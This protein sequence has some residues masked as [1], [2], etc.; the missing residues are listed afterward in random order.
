MLKEIYKKNILEQS[1]NLNNRIMSFTIK[2]P[3]L[4]KNIW[5][6]LSTQRLIMMPLIIFILLILLTLS[7][8]NC[9]FEYLANASYIGLILVLYLWGSKVAY[10][11]IISEYNERTW[12]WQRMSILTP[13]Q[14]V[15]G[16]L[17]GAP[18]Y[19][20]YGGI[21]CFI[22]WFFFSVGSEKVN[23][24]DLIINGLSFFMLII[25]LMSASIMFALLRIRKGSARNKLKSGQI[26]FA[27]IVFG[28]YF[29]G[30]SINESFFVTS[31][32]YTS[33]Q[34][35]TSRLTWSLIE[36]TFYAIWAVIGLHQ[37]FRH[38]L[39]YKNSAKLWYLFIFTSSI[40]KGVIWSNNFNSFDYLLNFILLSFLVHTI[41]I[42]Y[43]LIIFEVKDL[44][45]FRLLFQKIKIKDF[46][47]LSFNAP[48]WFLTFPL[49]FIGL[50]VNW[51]FF[52]SSVL[53]SNDNMLDDIFRLILGENRQIS[54]SY[55]DTFSLM[56]GIFFFIIRDFSL[57]LFLNFNSKDKRA[58]TAF[59]LYLFLLYFVFPIISSNN[60]FLKPFFYPSLENGTLACMLSPAIEVVTLFIL[61][62]RFVKSEF[63][64][65]KQD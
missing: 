25:A 30:D 49:I 29:I 55:F 51:L 26:I 4:Q 20:W 6:E 10:D 46:K 64:N 45:Q 61:L 19:N 41:L 16:K 18:I 23:F 47:Y 8:P 38:E 5:L 28:L 63:I 9:T 58:D 62:K 24:I 31:Y 48:L 40:F 32:N 50:L 56:L 2:N 15:I 14:L 33:Y 44:T 54:V 11:N 13:N 34:F 39:N 22:F 21:I 52:S 7:I 36:N 60:T 59:L 53:V 12:D 57:L 43:G 42:S 1:N 27:L 65:F 35:K 3:E 37:A 17:F